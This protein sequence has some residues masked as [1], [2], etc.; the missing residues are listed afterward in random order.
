MAL[1]GLPGPGSGGGD[2]GQVDLTSQ[3]CSFLISQSPPEGCAP[4]APGQCMRSVAPR[5]WWVARASAAAMATVAEP[6]PQKRFPPS[7]PQNV[8]TNLRETRRRVGSDEASRSSLCKVFTVSNRYPRAGTAFGSRTWEPQR[9]WFSGAALWSSRT[10]S[11]STRCQELIT[12]QQCDNHTG[13][14]GV[15]GRFVPQ[16]YR[17]S[18]H[19]D[20]PPA[21]SKQA[22]QGTGESSMPA[23]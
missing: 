21:C 6:R 12:D 13:A 20:S 10:T 2:F 14:A 7:H 19:P 16:P 23:R 17:Q 3:S 1:G 5:G 4:L 8:C 11:E 15:L 18:R 22:E 9:A